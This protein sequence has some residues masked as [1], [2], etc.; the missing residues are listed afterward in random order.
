M[1]SETV[2]QPQAGQGEHNVRY[3]KAKFNACMKAAGFR[4]VK[5][6]TEPAQATEEKPEERPEIRKA[7]AEPPPAE[8]PASPPVAPVNEKMPPAVPASVMAADSPY[9]IQLAAYRSRSAAE[10]EL[11]RLDAALPDVL[12]TR[13]TVIVKRTIPR[14]GTFY[15]IQAGGFETRQEARSMCRMLRAKRQDCFA[16]KTP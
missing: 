11:A 14:R 5:E 10:G 4:R 6:D 13:E 15:G 9:R 12:G 16:V 8:A 1:P 3:D 7:A 2:S